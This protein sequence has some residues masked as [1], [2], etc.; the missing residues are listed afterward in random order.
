MDRWEEMQCALDMVLTLKAQEHRLQCVE[1]P[2][3]LYCELFVGL[4]AFTSLSIFDIS[5][6]CHQSN[7]LLSQ[8][9][10]SQYHLDGSS[11]LHG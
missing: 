6:L 1:C 7:L 4:I 11:S 8:Q 5:L 9:Q 10:V 3:F 2:C